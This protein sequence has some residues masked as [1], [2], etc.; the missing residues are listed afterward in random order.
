MIKN[1]DELLS[2][3]PSDQLGQAHEIVEG[4]T[5]KSRGTIKNSIDTNKYYK[6][7]SLMLR[8]LHSKYDIPKSKEDVMM[9]IYVNDMLT[10]YR[11][12]GV[13]EASVDSYEVYTARIINEW[14]KR[15]W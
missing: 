12:E 14:Y 7:I 15:Y 2:D 9:N 4:I 1:L 11:N 13:I 5:K 3:V 8:S 10:Y 6:N